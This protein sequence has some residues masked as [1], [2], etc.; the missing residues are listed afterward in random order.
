MIN[1]FFHGHAMI[2]VR[3]VSN[4]GSFPYQLVIDFMTD[5]P[6]HIQKYSKINKFSSLRCIQGGSKVGCSQIFNARC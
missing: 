6:M 1:A 4:F 2:I 3:H 5:I